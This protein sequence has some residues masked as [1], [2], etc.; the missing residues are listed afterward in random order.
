MPLYMI[1]PLHPSRLR[2][3]LCGATVAPLP[4]DGEAP[5]GELTA[6]Q[7]AH[8]WPQLAADVAGHDGACPGVASG[9]V[10]VRVAE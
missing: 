9:V 7:V 10:R 8:L 5:P 3:D 2:C 1:D 6:D 4:D